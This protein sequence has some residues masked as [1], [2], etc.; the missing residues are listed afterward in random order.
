ME[1]IV[2]GPPVQEYYD[3]ISVKSGVPID[4]ERRKRRRRFKRVVRL[5]V[6]KSR[7]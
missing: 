2:V 4:D 5:Q 7:L 6:F 1:K 3:S